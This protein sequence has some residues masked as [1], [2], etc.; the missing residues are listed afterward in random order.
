M[1]WV[2]ARSLRV[3]KMSAWG[4]FYYWDEERTQPVIE[5][6]DELRKREWDSTAEGTLLHEMVHLEGK[7]RDNHGKVFDKR[8][9]RIAKLGAFHHVW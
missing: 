8:M 2:S 3:K 5:L 6:N 7:G 4:A 9:L 1:R